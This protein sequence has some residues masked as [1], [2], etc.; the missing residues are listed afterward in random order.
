MQMSIAP[1]KSF[2]F[3]AVLAGLSA[4]IIAQE[5]LLLQTYFKTHWQNESQFI[6][7]AITTDIAELSQELA[8]DFR[9]PA[10]HERAAVLLGVFALRESSGHFYDVRLPLCRMTAHL[11]LARSLKK[12]SAYSVH[13][14]LAEAILYTLMNNQRDA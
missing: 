14:R 8:G 9:N 7:E 1:K 12:D 2:V 11:A 5:N 6:V 13:G 4:Q 3:V 10:L